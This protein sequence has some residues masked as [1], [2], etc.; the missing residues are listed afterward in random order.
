MWMGILGYEERRLPIHL[1]AILLRDIYIAFIT[2]PEVN[3]K[4]SYLGSTQLHLKHTSRGHSA[5]ESCSL[6]P[7]L[8]LGYADWKSPAQYAPSLLQI[9]R[10]GETLGL[11]RGPVSLQG[12]WRVLCRTLFLRYVN[13][14]IFRRVNTSVFLQCLK[15]SRS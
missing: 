15:S 2:A 5:A 14:H 1:H 3:D 13:T 12:Y 6:M 9:L 7:F 11:G 4:R 8:S 10:H